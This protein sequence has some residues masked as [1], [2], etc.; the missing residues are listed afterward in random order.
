[1]DCIWCKN[2]SDSSTSV[3]H[4][5]PE[6][7]GNTQHI[8]PRGWVCD[9]CNNYFARKI[10]KPFLDSDYA[11]SIRFQMNIPNKRGKIPSI[12]ARLLEAKQSIEIFKDNIDNTLSISID[13]LSEEKQNEVIKY[14]QTAKKGTFFSSIFSLPTN[15]RVLSRFIAKIGLEIL[16]ASC[17]D[18]PD[19]N[20]EITHH[21]TLDEIRK[22]VRYGEPIE[23]LWP[24]NIRPLYDVGNLFQDEKEVFQIL[25]EWQILITPSFEYYAVICI[26]GIEYAINLGGSVIDGYIK[27]LKNHNNISPLYYDLKQDYC[28]YKF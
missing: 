23:L 17:I 6:S 13:H 21:P 1:M 7:F 27:W 15:D 25:N 5:L 2:N 28:K 14:L 26:F 4:I 11:K 24:I 8:L 22:Y 3:E 19:S 16:A 18:V 10:E 20:V 12:T 9:S